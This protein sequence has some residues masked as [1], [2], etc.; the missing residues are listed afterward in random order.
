MEFDA[1]REKVRERGAMGFELFVAQSALVVSPDVAAGALPDHLAYIRS[2]EESGALMMAG[3]LSDTD[4][5]Q[6]AGGLFVLKAASMAE[7]RRLMDGDP[8]HALGH[9]R[10]E[11][12]RWLVNEGGFTVRFGFSTGPARLA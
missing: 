10:Y 11:L 7:A 1:Y 8:M 9:R 2:L 4:G 3:P 6:V 12:R 5:R